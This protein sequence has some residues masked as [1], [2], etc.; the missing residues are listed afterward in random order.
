MLAAQVAGRRVDQT[1]IDVR[2]GATT[3]YRCCGG[4][5]PA[6]D[7]RLVVRTIPCDSSFA[8]PATVS[9]L[10]ITGP[11]GFGI[12]RA[13]CAFVSRMKK[14]SEISGT[15]SP[16]TPT[17]MGCDVTEALN[18]SVPEPGTKSTP[19]VAF[20]DAVCQSTVTAAGRAL[21][22]GSSSMTIP[23]S[24]IPESPSSMG[25][26]T[27]RRPGAVWV[28]VSARLLVGSGSGVAEVTVALAV[29][30]PV[31]PGGA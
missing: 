25:G 4:T 30:G 22:S 14:T 3:R 20:P 31:R 15:V 24:W 5:G 13:P 26:A 16:M 1:S 27:I 21:P 9:S 8:A 23:A 7:S 18:V 28:V 17:A 11:S 2:D 6:P 19:L 10:T 12:G 29:S